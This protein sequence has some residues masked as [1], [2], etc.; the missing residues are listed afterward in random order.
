MSQIPYR[1]NP[2]PAKC[3]AGRKMRDDISGQVVYE[4]YLTLNQDG[5]RVDSRNRRTLDDRPDLPGPNIAG[6]RG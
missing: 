3:K 4:D 6:N 5:Q 2:I 1:S